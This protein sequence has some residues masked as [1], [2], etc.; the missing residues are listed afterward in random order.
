LKPKTDKR[1]P[2]IEGNINQKNPKMVI[3]FSAEIARDDKEDYKTFIRNFLVEKERFDNDVYCLIR[4]SAS[5]RGPSAGIAYYLAL[6]SLVNQIPLPRNLGSTGTIKGQKVGA[7]GG[8]DLKLE[9]NAKK[10]PPINTFILSEENRKDR[11]RSQSYEDIP[12]YIKE[13][14]KQVEF[15]RLTN[16]IPMALERILNPGMRAQ[17]RNIP[18]PEKP[19]PKVAE[20]RATPEQ[21]LAF[22]FDYRF[23]RVDKQKDEIGRPIMSIFQAEFSRAG[24]PPE[25]VINLYNEYKQKLDSNP[26]IDE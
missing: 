9:Y 6:Y 14:I 10:N 11:I 1:D 21:L 8:L 16:E 19:E 2:Q 17:P 7:I 20:I 23:S 15:V 25:K 3:N 22:V 18:V 13:K 26:K 4:T 5:M 24:C 12:S